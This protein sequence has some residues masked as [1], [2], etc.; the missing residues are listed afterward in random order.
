VSTPE[1]ILVLII[2]ISLGL[3][4]YTFGSRLF[5]RPNKDRVVVREYGRDSFLGVANPI[6]TMIFRGA[7]GLQG[8]PAF[9]ARVAVKM[10]KDAVA[11]ARLGYRVASTHEYEIRSLG[12]SYVKVTY[13]LIEPP[14]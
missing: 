7:L 9:Q 14:K 1:L 10:E 3:L 13:E 12:V 11:M 2:A 5:G 6:M 8:R 4:A